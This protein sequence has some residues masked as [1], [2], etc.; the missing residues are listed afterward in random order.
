MTATTDTLEQTTEPGRPS[1]WVRFVLSFAVGLAIVLLIG[2][3]A[4]YAYDQQ[5][6]GRVLPGVRV[7]SVDLSGLGPDAARAELLAAYGSLS[8]G[9]IVLSGIEDKQVITYAEIGRE[10]GRASCRERV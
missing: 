2:V 10:I 4:L 6:V 5:Y 9:R 3:G 8:E 7:G 1:P